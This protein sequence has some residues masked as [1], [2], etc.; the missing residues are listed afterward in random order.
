[1][2]LALGGCIL[3][4]SRL[5]I[6]NSGATPLELRLEAP[7]MKWAGTIRAGRA[8]CMAFYPNEDG[9]FRVEGRR[10]DGRRIGPSDVDYY[11]VNEMMVHVLD[12]SPDGEVT[13]V[14]PEER[15]DPPCDP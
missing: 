9:S 2:C 5:V 6:I 11:T 15:F 3:N 12:V 13:P 10:P 7:S 8:H 1:M 4:R 14:V